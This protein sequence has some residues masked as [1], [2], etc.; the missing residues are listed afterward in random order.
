MAVEV[1]LQAGLE[2]L[3]QDRRCLLLS[4]LVGVADELFGQATCVYGCD[5]IAN[6]SLRL[7]ESI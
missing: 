3:G 7:H 6:A 2:R 1:D 4:L 5:D